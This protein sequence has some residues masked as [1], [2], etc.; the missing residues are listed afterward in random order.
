MTLSAKIDEGGFK[1]GFYA[2]DAAFE[3]TGLFLNAGAVF[4]IEVVQFLAIDQRNAQFF[5][6]R[7]VY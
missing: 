3:N 4:D 1:T 5:F 6:L 7:C 2:G